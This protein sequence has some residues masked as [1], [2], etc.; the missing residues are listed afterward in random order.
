[1]TG[2]EIHYVELTRHEADQYLEGLNRLTVHWRGGTRKDRHLLPRHVHEYNALQGL[3]RKLLA[4]VHADGAEAPA[5][6]GT[7]F[8]LDLAHENEAEALELEPPQP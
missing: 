8:D 5:E 7:R 1:M 6:E 2:P 4:V 3:I